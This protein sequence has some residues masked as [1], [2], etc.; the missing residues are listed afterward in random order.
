MAGYYGAM[1][2]YPQSYETARQ[3]LTPAAAES[4]SPGDKVVVY[5]DQL[6]RE[7]GPT[8][9]VDYRAL[10]QL[11]ERGAWGTTDP[12]S[13]DQEVEIPL[14]KVDDEWRIVTPPVGLHVE[15]RDFVTLAL[16]LAHRVER[17]LVLRPDRDEV[18]ALVLVEVR[19]ALQ[20]EV[21]R[22]GRAG[23]PHEL[24]RVAAHER[25]DVLARLLDRGFRRPPERV[26]A[27]RRV[28]ELVREVLDHL[29]GHARVD[30]RG[31]GVV[32]VDRQFHGQTGSGTLGVARW[33]CNTATSFGCCCFTSCASVTPERNVKM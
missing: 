25:R 4:W 13:A 30:R 22:L 26:R 9:R 16:E 7:S 1:L 33:S 23:R 11:D 28:A 3:F 2:A 18:L 29:L 6:I 19:G 21:D 31:R 12:A 20:R 8:V 10:G 14:T 15:V 5:D 17:R 27:R 24:L 32:E